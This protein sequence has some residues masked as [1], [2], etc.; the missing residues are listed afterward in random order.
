MRRFFPN[1]WKIYVNGVPK[2][3]LEGVYTVLRGIV[4]ECKAVPTAHERVNISRIVEG[5]T[6]SKTIFIICTRSGYPNMESD[7]K[8]ITQS[9]ILVNCK[10][11][12]IR[13]IVK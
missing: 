6:W 9:K 7:W 4:K 2:E 5:V 12:C 11:R 10:A 8:M 3:I 13:I 1:N